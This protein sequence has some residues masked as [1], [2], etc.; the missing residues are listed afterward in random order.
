MGNI[1]HNPRRDKQALDIEVS[2]EKDGLRLRRQGSNVRHGDELLVTYYH[3]RAGWRHATVEFQDEPCGMFVFTGYQPEKV[4]IHTK[5]GIESANKLR[6]APRRV[7]NAGVDTTS[8]SSHFL[9]DPFHPLNILSPFHPCR[10]PGPSDFLH[11][12][13]SP[14]RDDSHLST[15]PSSE[16]EEQPGHHHHDRHPHHHGDQTRPASPGE[17][18]RESQE[19]SLRHGSLPSAVE[20]SGGNPFDTSAV[21][22]S[23]ASA[24]HHTEPRTDYKNDEMAADSRGGR[25]IRAGLGQLSERHN[26]RRK[27]SQYEQR[28]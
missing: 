20:H 8:D 17:Q 6:E 11:L 2:I 14:Y 5:R 15:Q 1:D 28:L 12:F 18:T 10:C 22:I 23:P 25:F 27:Y 3:N 7:V 26:S 16:R 24:G 4:V 9:T 13:P 21:T 19:A